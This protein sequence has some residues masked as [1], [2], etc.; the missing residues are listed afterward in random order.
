M[1]AQGN[2]GDKILPGFVFPILADIGNYN[3][4]AIEAQSI[5]SVPSAPPGITGRLLT[6]SRLLHVRPSNESDTRQKTGSLA[7]I[8]FGPDIEAILCRIPRY[9]NGPP[10]MNKCFLSYLAAIM[11]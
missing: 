9:G 3:V 10:I 6:F 8:H 11:R 1:A 2:A 7:M 4:K 5:S